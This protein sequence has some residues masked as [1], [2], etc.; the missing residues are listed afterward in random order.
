MVA[1]NNNNKELVNFLIDKGVNVNTITINN[2][3]TALSIA[4]QNSNIDIV[5]CLLQNGANINFINKYGENPI[6]IASRYDSVD[7]VSLLIKYGSNIHAKDNNNI[8]PLLV[9]VYHKKNEII[10]TL[11]KAGANIHDSDKKGWTSIIIACC[12]TKDF[13]TIS[14]LLDYG[15]NIHDMTI[16]NATILMIACK[17][18]DLEMVKYVINKKVDVNAISKNG[19]NALCVSIQRSNMDIFKYLLENGANIN[20]KINEINVV[21]IAILFDSL[22]IGVY[23]IK[24]LGLSPNTVIYRGKLY[25][26]PSVYGSQIDH[27]L[28][29]PHSKDI[30]FKRSLTNEEKVSRIEILIQARKSYLNWKRRWPYM[31]FFVGHKFISMDSV[32]KTLEAN[33]LPFNMKIPN[34]ASRT[35]RQNYCNLRDKIFGSYILY[36]IIGFL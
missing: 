27:I 35:R 18:N 8:T 14:L 33:A 1:S 31:N 6:H 12:K 5:E 9:A 11:L 34:L 3:L 10:K 16:E 19:L 29:S 2:S 26:F 13:S 20:Y 32:R 21:D 17:N 25:I 28:K 7:I 15:A 24:N 30:N 4:I 36:F 23:L 22:D